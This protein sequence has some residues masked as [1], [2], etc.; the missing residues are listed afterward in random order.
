M[1]ISA[2]IIEGN[3]DVAA[4]DPQTIASSTKLALLF[5]LK[6]KYC[7]MLFAFYSLFVLD[8]VYLSGVSNLKKVV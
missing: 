2:F 3:D 1:T 5:F 7:K 6:Y 4:G 8:E